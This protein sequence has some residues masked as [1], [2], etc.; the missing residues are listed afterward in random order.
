MT[1]AARATVTLEDVRCPKCRK[2]LAKMEAGALKPGQLLE[3][4]CGA[5][6]AY[7]TRIGD[8]PD[9]QR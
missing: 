7:C 5:C 6:N 8:E 3:I 1:T 2:L 4:K 9:S